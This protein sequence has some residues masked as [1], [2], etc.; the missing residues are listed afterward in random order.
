MTILEAR[1][2]LGLGRDDDPRPFLPGFKDARERLA[3]MVR[4]APNETLADRYQKE[5]IEFD[6]A[7]AAIRESLEALGLIA[8]EAPVAE[9]SQPVVPPIPIAPEPAAP[10]PF[11]RPETPSEPEIERHPESV[12][13]ATIPAAIEPKIE[14]KPEKLPPPPE[15]TKELAV[16]SS[17]SHAGLIWFLAFI[18]LVV[19]GGLLFFKI[20][21]DVKV[22]NEMKLA[23]LQRQ[24]AGF[25]ENRRW[26][27]AT[28]AFNEIEAI[29]P[30]S[31]VVALGRRGIE[32][33]M[34]EE[35]NQYV[36]YWTGQA[37]ASLEANRWDEAEAA[38]RQ[39]IEKFPKEKEAAEIIAQI[40]S[41]RAE[42]A[43]RAILTSAREL[44]QE[45]KW[46]EA[47]ATAQKILAKRPEDEDA[48]ALLVEAT[49]AKEKA[50]ADLAKAKSLLNQARERDQGQFDQQILDWLREATALAPDDAEISA[51]LE[52]IAAY[53]RTVRV[54][55]DYATPA[56]AL[57]AARDRDRIILA[58]GKWE[59]PLIVNAAVDLQGDGPETTIVQCPAPLANAITLGP[60]AKGARISGISFRHESFDPGQERFSAAL[61]RGGSVD[62]AD[63]RFFEASGHGLAVI[64]GGHAI[65]SRC[66]F[67]DNGW[68][69]IAASGPGSLLEVRES[70]SLRNFGHGIESWD[71][72]AIILTANRCEDNSRNGI[73]ADNGG[74][75]VT[76]EKNQLIGNREFGLV[77]SSA[78][79]GRATGNIARGNLLGGFVIRSTAE[80]VSFMA[81]EANKNDGPGL[82]LDIGLLP[83]PYSQNLN[84]GN[85]GQQVLINANLTVKDPAPAPAPAAPVDPTVPPRALPVLEAQ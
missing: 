79:S 24:G 48:K 66:R 39:V 83:A 1:K 63:C 65:V 34:L 4:N 6:Q 49:V 58:A 15:P 31:E 18:L 14:I 50:A 44:L 35:Q 54:P 57:A 78:G 72:A 38:A 75:S 51:E 82:V 67:S 69:G 25:I 70:E 61:V 80:K 30:N 12:P 47:I 7:L 62:F 37:R 71:G 85:A 55:G 3:E 33:G 16:A 9:I 8:A 81:N 28:K 74:G 59:G 10:L 43:D 46:D 27:E 32:A 21:E 22:R 56:E 13:A 11:W 40:A 68:D 64:E 76:L 36:A 53:S 45:R 19:A 73:H 77:L 5:L 52:K 26:P 23:D 41:A 20:Q 2:I 42:A 60:Q 29:S 17:R 84:V